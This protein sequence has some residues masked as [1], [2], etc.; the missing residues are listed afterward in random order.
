[1]KEQQEKYNLPEGWL[2]TT[3]GDIAILSSGDT[4][5]RGN[6][7]YFNGDIPSVKSGEL[8]DNIVAKT[9]EA[10]TQDAIENSSAKIVPSEH[11]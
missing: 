8:N 2:W 11:Y 1:M 7:S 4:P 5:D 3:I 9:E 6:R 10:K